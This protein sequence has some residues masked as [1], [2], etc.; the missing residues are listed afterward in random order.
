MSDRAAVR[1]DERARPAG[2]RAERK[3][4]AILRA[5]RGL[6]LREGFDASVDQI[7]A[8]A[9][10]SKV[11]V[12]NHFGSKQALFV[13]VIKDATDAP[14]GDTLVGAVDGLAD[15]DDLR[16]VLVAAARAWVTEVRQNPDTLAVRNLVAREAHRFPELDAAW[17]EGGGPGVHHPA[18]GAALARLA[19]AGRLEIPDLEVAILQLYSLLVF[20]HLV[21]SAYGTGVDDDLAD[22]MVTGGVDMFL[23][24]YAPR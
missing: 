14:L 13:E 6:F 1:Q 3:R 4:A 23:S 11:T 7:A 12:Y 19:A 20:P 18:A 24:R 22:R 5:A 8:E 2:P 10:V 15:G 21:F 9:G 17:R 16:T